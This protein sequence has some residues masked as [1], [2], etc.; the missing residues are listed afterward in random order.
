MILFDLDNFSG[1]DREG[2]TLRNGIGDFKAIGIN[3]NPEGLVL[4]PKETG[5]EE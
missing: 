4:K 5:N 2:G 3:R 1:R